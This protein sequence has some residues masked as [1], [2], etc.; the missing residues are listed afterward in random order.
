MALEVHKKY[1]FLSRT[2]HEQSLQQ[3]IEE[4]ARELTEIQENTESQAEE[5]KRI[6]D[7]LEN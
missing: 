5:S 2:P 1:L 7:E 3:M 4:N 6:A